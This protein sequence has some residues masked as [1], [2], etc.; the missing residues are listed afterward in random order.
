MDAWF[1]NPGYTL[2]YEAHIT[3][4]ILL[5]ITFIKEEKVNGSEIRHVWHL[6]ESTWD[7]C[8]TDREEEAIYHSLRLD[9]H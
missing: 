8:E 3:K 2:A 7:D 9:L 4:S 5:M 6:I 1:L